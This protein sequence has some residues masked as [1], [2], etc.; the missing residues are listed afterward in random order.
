M[1]KKRL[2]GELFTVYS[3]LKAG[4]NEKGVSLFPLMPSDRWQESRLTLLQGRFRSDIRKDFLQLWRTEN[5][6]DCTGKG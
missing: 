5:G 4:C 6:I 2:R 1:E 3:Y